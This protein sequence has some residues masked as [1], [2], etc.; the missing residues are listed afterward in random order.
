LKKTKSKRSKERMRR[1]RWSGPDAKPLEVRGHHL[2]C[3]VCVRGG[4][5]K[6][7]PGK[8]VIERLLNAMWEYPYVSLKVLAD[9]DVIRAHYL[10][11]Y[12]KRNAKRLPKDF[13]KRKADY[14]W[15]RKDLEVCR[16]L[17]M[18]PNTEMP[19]FHVYSILFQ[20]QPTLEGICRTGSKKSKAW[21]E[22]PYARKGYYEKIAGGRRYSLREQTEEGEN[23]DGQGIWAM[24]R[25]RTREDM[26]KAK[27]KSA[28][29]ILNK[30][31]RLYMRPLHALCLFCREDM[32]NPIVEDNLIEMLKRMEADPNIPVTL[33]EGCCMACDPCNEYHAGE[34]LCYHTHIKNSLRDLMVLERLGLPPGATLPARELYQRIYDRIG[35][36]KEICGWRD[37][38]NTAPYWAPCDYTAPYLDNARKKKL[39]TGKRR[40]NTS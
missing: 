37:G 20:R 8:R 11:V 33:T 26:A 30:A 12:E 9:V 13:S 31:D 40:Q 38:S 10:D 16:V 17:G 32:T 36:L 19:A 35:S 5:R 6:P 27:D 3:A 4:C 23:M 21:P 14:V 34:N 25:P 15:R 28:K 39:I 24:L 1:N 2:L 29:F 7:P 22:C 18:V